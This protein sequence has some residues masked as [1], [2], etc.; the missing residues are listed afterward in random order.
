MPPSNTFH[1]YDRILNGE[2]GPLLLTWRAEG[3]T[4]DE[5]STRLR[6]RGVGVSR[7][8]VRRWAAALAEPNKAAKARAARK[9][10]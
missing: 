3:V 2:L 7:E 10:S 4:L 6:A 8:T 9:A 5:Q 1:L